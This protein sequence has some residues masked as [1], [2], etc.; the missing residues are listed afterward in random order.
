MK[1]KHWQMA[2]GLGRSPSLAHCTCAKNVEKVRRKRIGVL[3]LPNAD[4]VQQPGM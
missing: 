3:T 4:G 1:E 2:F